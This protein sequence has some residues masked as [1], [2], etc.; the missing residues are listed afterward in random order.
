MFSDD[1]AEYLIAFKEF[2]LAQHAENKDPAAAALI[3]E[4]EQELLQRL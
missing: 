4:I 2:L 3:A 1:P